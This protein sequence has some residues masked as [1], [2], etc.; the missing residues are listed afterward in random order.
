MA[1]SL[2]LLLLLGMHR[3]SDFCLLYTS[4]A[5]PLLLDIRA[6]RANYLPRRNNVE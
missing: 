2:G 5:K 6:R 3:W 1:D 4:L